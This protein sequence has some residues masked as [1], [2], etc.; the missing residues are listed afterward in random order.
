MGFRRNL[1]LAQSE[2]DSIIFNAS[3][4]LDGAFAREDDI[5]YSVKPATPKDK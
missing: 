2:V 5:D 4:E 1:W 3:K